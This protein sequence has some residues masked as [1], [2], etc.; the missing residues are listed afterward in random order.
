MKLYRKLKN[1]ETGKQCIKRILNPN[2]PK[3]SGLYEK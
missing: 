3:K 1:L 2:V